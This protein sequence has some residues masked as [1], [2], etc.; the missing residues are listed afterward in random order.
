MAEEAEEST[1]DD[2]RR[3]HEL[4]T[5]QSDAQERAQTREP[6]ATGGFKLVTSSLLSIV[7]NDDIN[8]GFRPLHVLLVGE[9][10]VQFEI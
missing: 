9:R 5:H 8:V 2:G 4:S 7:S 1:Q 10:I 3:A 6:T